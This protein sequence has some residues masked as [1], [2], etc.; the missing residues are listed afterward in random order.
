MAWKPRYGFDTLTSCNRYKTKQYFILC[1]FVSAW[2]LMVMILSTYT[3]KCARLNTGL[4]HVVYLC[5]VVSV[6]VFFLLILHSA[7]ML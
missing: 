2:E 3:L 7:F 5:L 1:T 4:M 6:Y